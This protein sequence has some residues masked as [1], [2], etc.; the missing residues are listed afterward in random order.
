LHAVVQGAELPRPLD[1][2]VVLNPDNG[3]DPSS[4]EFQAA[5]KACA[6]LAPTRWDLQQ[7]ERGGRTPVDVGL[8]LN[9]LGHRKRSPYAGLGGINAPRHIVQRGQRIDGE[10]GQTDLVR[11][12]QV[13]ERPQPLEVACPYNRYP[14]TD[15]SGPAPGRLLLRICGRERTI[16]A[17]A[18]TGTRA[19]GP[20]PN[21]RICRGDLHQLRPT[22]PNA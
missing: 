2:Q 8:E 3:I 13:R 9:H 11:R 4:P 15:P 19:A 17:T 1:G 21:R 10:L 14:D 6:S 12:Q 7:P 5:E 22:P 16:R 18:P 20:S